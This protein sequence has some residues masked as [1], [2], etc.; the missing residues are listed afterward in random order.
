MRHPGDGS[1]LLVRNSLKVTPINL[2]A[3]VV[4]RIDPVGVSVDTHL[5]RVQFLSVYAPPRTRIPWE[6]WGKL[7]RCCNPSDMM[8]I[9][10]DLQCSRLGLRFQL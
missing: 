4:S 10:G 8:I 7:L 5:G 3:R 6:V 1:L 9:C 2:E